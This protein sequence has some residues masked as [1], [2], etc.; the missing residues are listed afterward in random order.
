MAL[1]DLTDPKWRIPFRML[2]SS[3]LEGQGDLVCLLRITPM[4][5][6]ITSDIPMSELQCVY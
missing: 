6:I 3:L 4:S 5:H 1:S 2:E